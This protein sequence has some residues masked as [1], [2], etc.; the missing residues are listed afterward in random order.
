[1]PE[2]GSGDMR[3]VYATVILAVALIVAIFWLTSKQ[4]YTPPIFITDTSLPSFSPTNTHTLTPTITLSVTSAAITSTKTITVTPTIVPYT[5]T[6]PFPTPIIGVVVTNNP[7]LFR[8]ESWDSYNE[9]CQNNVTIY[10][11]IISHGT[12]PYKFTF[13][14]QKEPYTSHLVIVKQILPRKNSRDYV[15]FIP[16]VIVAKGSYK[17]VELEFQTS[18]GIQ[19]AWADDLFYPYSDDE[20]CN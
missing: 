16:P 8:V 14:T 5:N 15:E 19:V 4:G 12:P 13:W 7:P 11:V 10:G 17:H 18:D 20:I 2:K 6:P 1:M 3:A 9:K